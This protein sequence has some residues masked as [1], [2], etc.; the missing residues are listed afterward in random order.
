VGLYLEHFFRE[1]VQEFS[2]EGD[3]VGN[4]SRFRRVA[5]FA[6]KQ[7]ALRAARACAW[8]G[9]FERCAE[10]ERVCCVC[11]VCVCAPLAFTRISITSVAANAARRSDESVKWWRKNSF[12]LRSALHRGIRLPPRS[13][14]RVAL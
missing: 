7:L 2:R 5:H 13:N 4:Q 10:S 6:G 11:Y 8:L 3:Q 12:N 14:M 1:T 9:W